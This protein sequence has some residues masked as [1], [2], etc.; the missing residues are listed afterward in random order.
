MEQFLLHAHSG[1]RHLVLLM[2]VIAIIKPLIGLFGKA[3][4]WTKSDKIVALLFPIF[5]DI[6]VMLGMV[7]WVSGPWKSGGPATIRFEHPVTMLIALGVAHFGLRKVKSGE[8]CGCKHK[9]AAAWYF[10]SM[11]IILLGVVRIIL[12]KNG[13]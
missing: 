12:A 11:M 13:A 2:G 7:L 8:A 4:E 5:L 6:Q 1:W 9:H 10:V 3:K